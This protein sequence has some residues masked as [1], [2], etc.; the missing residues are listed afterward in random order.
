VLEFDATNRDAIQG[1]RDIAESF[2]VMARES[3]KGGDI[4]ESKHLVTQG[5]MADPENKGLFQLQKQ[6]NSR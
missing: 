6:L 1:L 5:L 2:D 4:D 3:L